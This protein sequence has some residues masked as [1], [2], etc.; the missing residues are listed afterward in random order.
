[1]K[2]SKVK[3]HNQV[4]EWFEYQLGVQ[5]GESL[6]LF[7]FSMYLNDIEDAFY[8]HG[9]EGVNIYQIKLF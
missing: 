7:L 8:L 3:Y 5:Q 6:S 2:Q 1:M 9:I 4:S